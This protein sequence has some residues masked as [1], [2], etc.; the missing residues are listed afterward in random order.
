MAAMPL[1]GPPDELG[2]QW[3]VLDTQARKEKAPEGPVPNLL[4]GFCDALRPP[5]T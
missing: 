5:K 1:Q 2:S 3:Q 4:P